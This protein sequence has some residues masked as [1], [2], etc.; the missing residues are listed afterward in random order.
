MVVDGK[1]PTFENIASG[2]Y[3]IS[4]SLYFYIKGEHVGTVP[5]MQEYVAEFTGEDAAGDEGYLVDKGLIP[6]SA[7]D[8]AGYRDDGGN[9]KPLEGLY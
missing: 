5:G 6:L 4:R 3:P 7:D 1:S 8:L 2:A 9:L